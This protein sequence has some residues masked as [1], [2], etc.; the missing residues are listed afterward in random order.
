MPRR[1]HLGCNPIEGA[2]L[3]AIHTLRVL[4]LQLEE[5]IKLREI[6][7]LQGHASSVTSLLSSSYW[8]S[9][10]S[11]INDKAVRR[12]THPLAHRCRCSVGSQPSVTSVMPRMWHLG[13]DWT[14]YLPLEAP[15]SVPDLKGVV[16]AVGGTH[17]ASPGA[18]ILRVFLTFQ[19]V[20]GL[21][22]RQGR[23][24]W[25]SSLGA[26]MRILCRAIALCCLCDATEAAPGL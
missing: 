15:G 2:P 10:T 23:E 26:Q 18:H 24:V 5:H 7:P 3:E 4:S 13:C 11:G 8:E 12:G 20:L 21:H 19:L 6:K 22:Q 1:L 17:Q 14:V 16:L 25:I 9:I